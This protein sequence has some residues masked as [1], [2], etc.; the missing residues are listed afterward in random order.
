MCV[1]A[2]YESFYTR[3][4]KNIYGHGLPD[5]QT[6]DQRVSDEVQWKYIQFIGNLQVLAIVDGWIVG[7]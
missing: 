5:F 2:F 7:L 4:Y 3:I 1:G 6:L